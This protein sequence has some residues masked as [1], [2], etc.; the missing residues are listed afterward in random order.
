MNRHAPSS[1]HWHPLFYFH[2]LSVMRADSLVLP[3]QVIPPSSED[4]L[5]HP[6]NATPAKRRRKSFTNTGGNLSVEN[7][8][9]LFQRNL[10]PIGQDVCNNQILV[11]H[12][13]AQ[14]DFGNEIASGTLTAETADVHM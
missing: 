6:A 5:T 12:R 7:D 10:L 14:F 4:E 3:P 11:L 2:S 9:A 8:I 13:V 1:E